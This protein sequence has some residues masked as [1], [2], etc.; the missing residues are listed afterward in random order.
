[1]QSHL[2]RSEAVLLKLLFKRMACVN[3]PKHDISLKIVKE[4]TVI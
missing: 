2:P 4:A 1:M 3:R